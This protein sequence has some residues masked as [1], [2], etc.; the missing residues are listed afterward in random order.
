MLDEK[1]A[2]YFPQV[3]EGN[4]WLAAVQQNRK[5]FDPPFVTSILGSLHL[6]ERGASLFPLKR[7]V[8][9]Q[10]GLFPRVEDSYENISDNASRYLVLSLVKREA[11]YT[12]SITASQRFIPRNM[13]RITRVLYVRTSRAFL[14]LHRENYYYTLPNSVAEL[15]RCSIPNAAFPV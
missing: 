4:I 15:P 9:R 14:C 12:S 8:K 5:P 13:Q 7:F 11:V 6:I 3:I 10:V 1:R 2:E